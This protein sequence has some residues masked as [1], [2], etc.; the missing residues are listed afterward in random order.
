MKKLSTVLLLALVALTACAWTAKGTGTQPAESEPTE[1]PAVA[2]VAVQPPAPEPEPKEPEWIEYEATA[3]C[4]CEKCCGSWAL[5][6]P[7]GI[8]YT[9]SGAVAEQG[10]TIA[11]D[12]DVLPPGT[13]VYI[14]G[15][16]E[17]V[18]QDRGG[19]IKGNAVDIYF[20]DHDEA[21]VFGRQAVRLY[22]IEERREQS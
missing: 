8:A 22:I 12:W 19:A 2:A 5:N 1:P 10:V 13:I 15:L 21:L 18:V 3:Y 9:A 20:E 7:D 6:R 16:G 14:D 11:A 17:R 4:S